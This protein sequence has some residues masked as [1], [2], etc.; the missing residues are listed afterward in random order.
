M[1]RRFGRS[2]RPAMFDVSKSGIVRSSLADA[3]AVRRRGLATDSDVCDV[4][5]DGLA[6]RASPRMMRTSVKPFRVCLPF[7]T[8]CPASHG[9]SRDSHGQTIARRSIVL[10][11]IPQIHPHLLATK[12]W[13][14]VNV[15][16]RSVGRST[17]GV[18]SRN[19]GSSTG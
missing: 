10:R 11:E 16:Q 18:A 6:E 9:Q 7:R 8:G 19:T 4:E 17:R 15:S 3:H 2:T 13:Q 1:L 5:R 12:T 14:H